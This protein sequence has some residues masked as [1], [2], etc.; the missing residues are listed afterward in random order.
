MYHCIKLGLKINGVISLLI[1]YIVTCLPLPLK[2]KTHV[3]LLAIVKKKLFLT[4][5]KFQVKE[6]WRDT[7]LQGWK[8]ETDYDF[9]LMH[10]PSVGL[11][12]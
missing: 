7:K 11:I 5:S 8:D 6:I 3:L 1:Y 2:K 9:R 10:R 12:R 4:N